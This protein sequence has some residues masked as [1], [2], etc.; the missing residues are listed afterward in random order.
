[1]SNTDA[2]MRDEED[3]SPLETQLLD[4]YARLA[5]NL[6]QVRREPLQVLNIQ[7]L[8]TNC[9]VCS[10]VEQICRTSGQSFG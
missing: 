3:L 6:S 9:N 2:Q 4:E 1:M 5:S 7:S 8:A 10:V